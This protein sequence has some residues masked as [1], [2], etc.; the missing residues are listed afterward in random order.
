[1]LPES[2][3]YASLAGLPA[4]YGIYCCL[5]GGI[6]FA[7]FTS[8]NQLAVG[9]TSAISLM[10]GTTV[11]ILAKGDSSK[12][13]AIASLTALAVF[14]FCMLAYLLK[15]SSLVNFISESILVGF[16]T[17]AA[18]SIATTQLPKLFGIVGEGDNSFERIYSLATRLPETNMHVLLFGLAALGLLILG[19]LLLPGRPVVLIVVILSMLFVTYAPFPIVDLKL[20]GQIPEGLPQFAIPSIQFS[21]VEGIL[22][23]AFGCFLMGY[24]ETISA[25][26]TLAA[27][28]G[29]AIDSRQELLSMGAAN[30]GTGLFSGYPV[31]GGLSQSSVNDR[32]GSKTPVALIISS[33]I[34]AI[35][36][37]NFTGLFKNLPEVILAVIVIDAILGFIRLRELK[38]IAKMNKVEYY[39]ALIAIFGVLLF[40]ILQGI[41]I[42]AISSIVIILIRASSP[43]IAVLGRIPGTDM[44]SDISRH[45]DNEKIPGCEIYRVETSL[46]YFN[47]QNIYT[48]IM[49][50]VLSAKQKPGMVI[51]D[52]SSSPTIDIAGSKMILKLTKSLKD[53]GISLRLVE[54]LS[55]VREMLRMHGLEEIIGHISRKVSIRDVIAELDKK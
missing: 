27:K 15:L 20:V 45:P 32:A 5:A 48:R 36:L 21:D 3:A 46:F 18:L 41:L 40:G 43:K 39:V 22:G 50:M 4:Q 12:V 49:E 31:S 10:V 7:L 26:R 1:M 33:I 54:A 9:P 37:L 55:E 29:Y 30:L 51:L 14:F 13:L 28:N 38:R 47:E 11:A 35:I 53:H 23:L 44:F 19:N 8:S 25:G 24:I 16:K 34:L 2:M 42:A 52:M 6:L 17:G